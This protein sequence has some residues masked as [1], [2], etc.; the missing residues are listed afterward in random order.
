MKKLL[1]TMLVLTLALAM[2]LA[3]TGCAS[4]DLTAGI[5]DTPVAGATPGEIVSDFIAA[6]L[7][8][9]LLG[10]TV[11]F[12]KIILPFVKNTLVPYLEQKSLF[13]TIRILV[14]AAEKQGETGVIPKD[15]KKFYVISWLKTL[16]IT[17][18]KKEEQMIEAAVEELDKMG[19]AI[20]E[21]VLGEPLEA[22]PAFGPE[23]PDP[24]S[25][26]VKDE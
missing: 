9:V 12:T 23:I 26:E 6:A 22:G 17:V 25:A 4:A 5:P 18:T 24:G 2:A 1:R 7:R 14:A 19:G 3:L 16:G 13:R 20:F 15:K 11:L 10:V 21:A 8:L